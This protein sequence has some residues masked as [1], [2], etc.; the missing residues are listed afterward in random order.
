MEE[1]QKQLILK[2]EV[3]SLKRKDR[4]K[5]VERIHRQNEY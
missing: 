3:E 2:K 1:K 4:L 5:T